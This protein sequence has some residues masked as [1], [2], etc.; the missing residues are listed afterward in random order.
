MI[1]FIILGS[2][3]VYS[4][5]ISLHCNARSYVEKQ[6]SRGFLYI[7][8]PPYNINLTLHTSVSQN[9]ILITTISLLLL[10]ISIRIESLING[11]CF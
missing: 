11:I 4:K 9:S 7:I 5:L 6:K 8:L 3:K 2:F 1:K 10:T